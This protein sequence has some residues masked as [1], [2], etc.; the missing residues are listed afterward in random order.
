MQNGGPP[1]SG[2]KDLTVVI[3]T[4][5]RADSLCLTLKCLAQSYRTELP[6]EILVV[7]NGSVDATR[8]VV[9]SF[10]SQVPIRYLVES[11]PGKGHS[12]NRALE[13]GGLGRIFAGLD[14]DMS[15]DHGWFEKVLD[16]C[17]RLPDVGIFGGHVY[18]E[19]PAEVAPQWTKNCRPEV[20]GWAFSA[21]SNGPRP[22]LTA[23][24]PVRRDRWP[25]GNHFWFRTSLLDSK[26]RFGESWMP[27]PSLLLDFANRGTKTVICQRVTAG[28]RIQPNLWDKAVVRTRA[29]VVGKSFASITLCPYRPTLKY[30]RAFHRFPVA[31]RLY[32]IAMLIRFS[33]LYL[34]AR[35]A[36]ARDLRIDQELHALERIEFF[37]EL[38]RIAVSNSAYRAAPGR[39]KP[40]LV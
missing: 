8:E 29:K 10:R 9:D 27:G 31:M 35:C 20:L 11:R 6:V 17:L 14:D 22:D 33:G 5:N 24:Q 40:A 19:W 32:S 15:P 34:L 36:G 16:S 21:M 39:K 25:S 30:P 23:D 13:A 12:L 26:C 18:I 28:H 3:C 4:R 37:S 2:R 7:D 1:D 38:L